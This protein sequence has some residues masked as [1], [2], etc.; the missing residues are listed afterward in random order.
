[1]GETRISGVSFLSSGL[2]SSSGSLSF[3]LFPSRR[4]A[5]GISIFSAF[6]WAE[7]PAMTTRAV[8]PPIRRA[9]RANRLPS[10]SA[11]AVTVQLLTT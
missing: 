6:A 9:L 4:S 11:S 10:R 1:M 8:A 5:S 7:H 3:S 2:A